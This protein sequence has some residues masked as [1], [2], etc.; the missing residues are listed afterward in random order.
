M[1]FYLEE[2]RGYSEGNLAFYRSSFHTF[3]N[4]C[5]QVTGHNPAKNLRHYSGVPKQIITANIDDLQSALD[6]C[7]R[8]SLSDSA[9][10]RR[11]A[12]IFAL[13]ATGLRRS[14]IQYC[15]FSDAVNALENPVW[16]DDQEFFLLY[17]RGKEPMEAILRTQTATV[18][19]R[20]LEVRPSTRHD[21]LFIVFNSNSDYY[22]EPL[23]AEGFQR[24]RRRICKEAGIKLMCFKKMR[25]LIGTRVARVQGVEV[26]AAV[27]G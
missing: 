7:D 6:A 2:K 26:A 19:R 11:D 3:F 18:L 25:R 20:Y 23:S 12:A 13:G 4:F 22:G 9:V 27:L 10:A 5:S 8:L 16:H 21:R 1:V 14:N 24:A 17:T 15:R